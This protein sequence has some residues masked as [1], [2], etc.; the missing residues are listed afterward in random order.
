MS[1]DSKL[2]NDIEWR[3]G[4]HGWRLDEG[5][6]TFQDIARALLD[7]RREV[8]ALK[9]YAHTHN[10]YLKAKLEGKE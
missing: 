2:W 4:F 1:L 3:L 6:L 9:V 5:S 8:E 7:L 10:A